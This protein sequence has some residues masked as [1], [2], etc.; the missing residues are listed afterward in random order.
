MES[1]VVCLFYHLCRRETLFFLTERRGTSHLNHLNSVRTRND[2]NLRFRFWSMI[3]FLVHL[4]VVKTSV[5]LLVLCAPNSNPCYFVT[6]TVKS[7]AQL[8]SVRLQNQQIIWAWVAPNV[9]LNYPS[10][11]YLADINLKLFT[12]IYLLA[13][14]ELKWT[15]KIIFSSY[16]FGKRVKFPCLPQMKTELYV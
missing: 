3:S 7:S 15:F 4:S 9:P 1:K 14:W 10:F 12:F 5:F 2:T 11:L 6:V 13:T 16:H 8:L